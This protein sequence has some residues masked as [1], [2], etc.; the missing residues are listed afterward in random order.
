MVEKPV[1]LEPIHSDPAPRLPVERFLIGWANWTLAR[2]HPGGSLLMYRNVSAMQKSSLVFNSTPLSRRRRDAARP[3]TPIGS[4]K[5]PILKYFVGLQTCRRHPS[6]NSSLPVCQN[7][8]V[9]FSSTRRRHTTHT[10][11]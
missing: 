3:V 2:I 10:V 8:H 11:I 9:Y 4:P 6:A 7:Q 5:L 1:G